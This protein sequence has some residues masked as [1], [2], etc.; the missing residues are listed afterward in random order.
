MTAHNAGKAELLA[1]IHSLRG[2][3]IGARLFAEAHLYTDVLGIAMRREQ[4]PTE[5]LQ[6]GPLL[7][8]GGVTG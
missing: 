7:Q 2:H 6:V 1:S 8:P 5:K 3:L 4:T